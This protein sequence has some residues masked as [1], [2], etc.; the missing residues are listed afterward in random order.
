MLAIYPTPTKESFQDSELAHFPYNEGGGKHTKHQ[1]PYEI[2]GSLLQEGKVINLQYDAEEI[3]LQ[4]RGSQFHKQACKQP[5][6]YNEQ[7]RL[8]TEHTPQM[9]AFGTV[10]TPQAILADA[11]HVAS[12]EEVEKVQHT[13]QQNQKTGYGC[14]ACH[15]LHPCTFV[16]G[17]SHRLCHNFQ[18]FIPH[19]HG[20][21]LFFQLL[22]KCLYVC[23]L[24]QQSV[25]QG[26]RQPRSV[27]AF[28][29]HSFAIVHGPCVHVAHKLHAVVGRQVLDYR[30]YGVADASVTGCAFGR[31]EEPLRQGHLFADGLMYIAENLLC[32]AFAQNNGIGSIGCHLPRTAHHFGGKHGVVG[33]VHF[34]H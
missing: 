9:E 23:T 21:L 30:L 29:Q 6:C 20:E 25:C 2:A 12:C 32:F 33:G 8:Y 13:Y 7:S 26:A 10:H 15:E 11:G 22:Y 1:Q 27:H 14:Y 34:H 19:V 5:T 24:F 3:E 28:P 16:K 17:F 31:R 18:V 4:V